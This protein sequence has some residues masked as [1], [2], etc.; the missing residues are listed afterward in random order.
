MWPKIAI[1]NERERG[2]HVDQNIQ[3]NWQLVKARAKWISE[4]KN[5]ENKE[6]NIKGVTKD[7]DK[8]RE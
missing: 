1:K 4:R 6:E 3:S 8:S 2:R 7:T 5:C